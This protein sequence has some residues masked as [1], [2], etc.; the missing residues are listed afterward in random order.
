MT[1][2][3]IHLSL[4][5]HS[6]TDTHLGCLYLFIYWHIRMGLDGFCFVLFSVNVLNSYLC[7]PV[8]V[9]FSCTPFYK[10]GSGCTTEICASSNRWGDLKPFSK[11]VPICSLTVW[12]EK[13][14][15]EEE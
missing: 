9:V 4:F 6:D 3:V 12:W 5:I 15:K 7:E 13:K 10:E 1:V 8:Q 14:E 11:V 2:R